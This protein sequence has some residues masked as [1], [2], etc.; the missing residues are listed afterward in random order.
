MMRC[1]AIDD[2]PLAL[3][4]I[5]KY[6]SETPLVKL[7]NTFTDAIQALAWLKMK[8]VDLI[9]LDIHMPDISG[10]QFITSLKN[11]PLVIFTTAFPQYAVKGFDLEAVDYL[12]KPIKSE[13]FLKAVI[14]AQKILERDQPASI[15][16]EGYTFVKS[17]YQTIKI[18]FND[19]RM[20]EGQDDYIKIHLHSES[21]PLLSLMS[22]KSILEKLPG[23]K[24]MRVHRSYIVPLKDIHC[25]RNK[26]I[27]LKD[28]KVPVGDT[29][30][31]AIQQ[32]LSGI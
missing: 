21:S 28:D 19:I 22:L 9:F 8:K 26:Y 5:R 16:G 32:W 14:K 20:I 7:E 18:C 27:Y 10:I 25:I 31:D 4:V 3:E 1:I 30:H 29:Y 24:F 11:P 6:C 13:R 23:D 17:G 15:P 2:E 12:V